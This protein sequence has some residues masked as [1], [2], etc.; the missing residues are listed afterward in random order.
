MIGG[1]RG[2]RVGFYRKLGGVGEGGRSLHEA[3][4]RTCV[5]RLGKNSALARS[6][7]LGESL[8]S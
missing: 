7:K 2:E 8:L 3:I 6:E 1:V 5:M 4:D